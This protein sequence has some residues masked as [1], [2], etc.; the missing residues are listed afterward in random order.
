MPT[1]M[2]KN[3]LG[4]ILA[5]LVFA[6]FAVSVLMIL[7]NGA[8]IVQKVSER[9]RASFDRRTAAQYVTTRIR[10]AD[11]AGM[12]GVRTTDGRDVLVLS[13]EID[14][15]VYETLVYC[16][17]GYLREMF[18]E[19]GLEQDPEFGEK[20]LPLEGFETGI[21]DGVL[22]IVITF[23]DGDEERLIYGLRSERGVD[24]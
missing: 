23:A 19:S 15:Y 7:L 9:D 18:C 14:G 20:I 17:D 21:E 22:R 4:G 13:E 12:I 10:Q 5:L 2:K 24:A 6:V 11:E 8:D 1:R 3:N 16:C